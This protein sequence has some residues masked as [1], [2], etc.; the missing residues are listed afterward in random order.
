MAS[1][2]VNLH[3]LSPDELP[4]ASRVR[5]ARATT[6]DGPGVNAENAS[7]T[8]TPQTTY[9]TLRAQ[10]DKQGPDAANTNAS[11]SHTANNRPN[12]DGS[13][14]G[15]G[16]SDQRDSN[17]QPR[18]FCRDHHVWVQRSRPSRPVSLLHPPMTPATLFH[19]VQLWGRTRRPSEILS[20]VA[21][22]VLA[23]KWHEYSDEAIQSAIARLSAVESP[24]DTDPHPYHTALHILS[25]ALHN[26]SRVRLELE[27]SRKLE[28][29]KQK[30]GKQRAEALLE[31]LLPSEQEVA[32][33]VIQSIFTDDD[34]RRHRVQ[35][36]E[37]LSSL[38]TS[39]TE[40]LEDQVPRGQT[41]FAGEGV[42]TST[43]SFPNHTAR[44]DHLGD[45]IPNGSSSLPAAVKEVP[46]QSRSDTP[47]DDTRDSHPPLPRQ[48]RASIG[49]WM[50]T[51][52]HRGKSKHP[53]GQFPFPIK[54]ETASK[55][56][57]RDTSPHSE[58]GSQRPP[59]R[60]KNSRSVFES[61][62][63]S[64]LNPSTSAAG[65]YQ[66]AQRWKTSIRSRYQA[67]SAPQLAIFPDPSEPRTET[68]TMQSPSLVDEKRAPQGA[69]L[70]AIAHA[71]RVMTSDPGSILDQGRD[72]GPLIRRLAL[73]LVQTAR[74]E[75]IIFRELPKPRERKEVRVEGGHQVV[76]RATLAPVEGVAATESLSRTL[77]SQG[78]L[79]RKS[80]SADRWAYHGFLD[81]S[82]P[83][84]LDATTAEE[85]D[86]WT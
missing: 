16:K 43:P 35:R 19:L 29:E 38:K 77:N 11:T 9:F 74:D 36:Q 27:N 22:Q 5:R 47:V 72:A 65:H 73:D 75:H 70:R 79:V 40:A 60:R 58:V 26:L 25:S 49:E 57:S 31:E 69:S 41:V 18:P 76:A 3:P 44:A 67:L 63:I 30:A 46:V 39:L 52:L 8:S 4:Q 64:I 21:A 7:S 42:T 68:S 59:P 33:R 12:W 56:S 32:R 37:S 62:G 78:Q 13:V 82:H 71:T 14:R 54:E 15:F 53:R 45:A 20:P 55:E 66:T 10:L 28:E 50:G 81:Y 24:S 34:E 80:R 2:P 23:H 1:T 51:W 83:Q 84:C 61:L 6:Q 17:L 48:D 86:W 85:N